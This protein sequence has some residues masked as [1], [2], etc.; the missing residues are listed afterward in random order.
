VRFWTRRRKRCGFWT[1]ICEKANRITT[2]SN[3]FPSRPITSIAQVG[4]PPN[5][6]SIRLLQLLRL[7]A[8]EKDPGH[9][10]CSGQRR[11]QGGEI[12][13]PMRK[14]FLTQTLDNIRASPIVQEFYRN[15]KENI[16][17]ICLFRLVVSLFIYCILND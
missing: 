9:H 3:P 5:D 12:Y 6:C 1:R 15:G 11:F 16:V 4:S 8:V 17:S 7:I 2:M 13:V 14:N 10:W